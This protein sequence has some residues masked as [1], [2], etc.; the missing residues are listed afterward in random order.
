MGNSS[1]EHNNGSRKVYTDVFHGCRKICC[2]RS[3]NASLFCRIRHPYPSFLFCLSE[4]LWFILGNQAPLFVYQ[5]GIGML[6]WSNGQFES[7]LQ[8][9]IHYCWHK[10]TPIQLLSNSHAPFWVFNPRT[11]P[12]FTKVLTLCSLAT[13]LKNNVFHFFRLYIAPVF[14]WSSNSLYISS[15]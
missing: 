10:W 1:I 13:I 15:S 11:G 8:M 14:F 7:K 4:H 2:L 3:K 12:Y 6:Y 9:F 5:I